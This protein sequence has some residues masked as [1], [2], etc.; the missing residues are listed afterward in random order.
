MASEMPGRRRTFAIGFLEDA[1]PAAKVVVRHATIA[2]GDVIHHPFRVPAM[3]RNAGTIPPPPA[4]LLSPTVGPIQRANLGFRDPPRDAISH[5]A[6]RYFS[7]KPRAWR[8]W[9]R[10][11]RPIRVPALRIRPAA[12]LVQDVSDID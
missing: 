8:I 6:R 10:T 12:W 1:E 9:R 4:R 7:P 2:A 5:G 3:S 11:C